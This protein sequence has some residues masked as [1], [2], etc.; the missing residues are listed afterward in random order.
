MKTLLFAAL[1]ALM[2]GPAWGQTVVQCDGVR[3]CTTDVPCVTQ[4]LLQHNQDYDGAVTIFYT[5]N[6]AESHQSFRV[7]KS[8]E[9]NEW[10]TLFDGGAD[11][12]QLSPNWFALVPT[13]YGYDLGVLNWTDLRAY[14]EFKCQFLEL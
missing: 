9:S 13:I 1:T 12:R 5:L 14:G 11:E 10:V 2:V 7:Q 4:V 3:R 6:G 8:L